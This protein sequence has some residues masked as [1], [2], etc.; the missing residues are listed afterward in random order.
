MKKSTPARKFVR[1]NHI[2][3]RIS[4]M[5]PFALL[6]SLIPFIGHAQLSQGGK[7]LSFDSK[8]EKTYRIE[9]MPDVD[10]QKAIAED[11]L[12]DKASPYRFGINIPVDL[13]VLAMGET[14]I[15]AGGD[16]LVRFGIQSKGALSLNLTF[17]KFKL[18][19]GGKLFIYNADQT[20]VIGAFTDFN[21]Q[22][23]GQFATMLLKG[24]EITLEYFEPAEVNFKTELTVGIVTHGYKDVFG[25]AKAFG[26]SGSCETNVNCPVAADWQCEKRS[27]VM[28]LVNNGSGLCS[29]ALVNNTKQ[30]KA[31]LVLTAN[32]CY[33]P[34]QS[35]STWVFYF[36]WESATCANP[37]S[38]PPKS[39][40]MTGATLKANS[41]GSDFAL[42]QINNPVPDA[43]NASYAGWSRA[44]TTVSSAFAIHH[45]SGD[46]KKFS[47]AAGGTVGSATVNLG[48]GPADCWQTAQWT[49]G[50]TEPGS[51]GSPL[52]DPQHRIVGQLYG[53]PSSCT[54]SAANKFDYYGKFHV[55]WTGG[56]SSATRLQDWLDPNGSNPTT[57]NTLGCAPPPCTLAATAT[58]SAPIACF[59]GTT[60]VVVSATGGAAPVTGTGTF[61]VGTGAY[62]FTVTD[63]NGCKSTA[64]GNISQPTELKATAVAGTILCKGGTTTVV[65]SATGGTAPYTGTGTFTVSAGAYSFTV[66]DKNGCKKTVSGSISEPP[67]LTVEAGNCQFVYYGYGSNCATLT[68]VGAGGV[69][70]Y[71]YSWSSGA[72]TASASVCPIITTTYTVTVKDANGCKATDIVTVEVIDVRCGNNMDKVQICHNGQS[73]CVAANS[74]ANHLSH[75]DKLGVCGAPTP[76]TGVQALI[77]NRNSS[78]SNKP[79]GDKVEMSIFPNPMQTNITVELENITEGVAQLEIL[80]MT[81]RKVYQKTESMSAGFNQ[82]TLDLQ[83]LSKGLYLVRLRDSNNQEAMVK[84]NKM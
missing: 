59:G 43:F 63:A 36:N 29:G 70:G 24:D 18:P 51:S 2:F 52:F 22:K 9:T 81:G 8:M 77:S 40:T 56:G 45:P 46:I 14:Q 83:S 75:G 61:T 53:G 17:S 50:V 54:A 32:H 27:V 49:L 42:V 6:L 12:T 62:S 44:G 65:V 1:L 16:K 23:D 34:A 57:L 38:S 66:T 60:T 37:S 55:S 79:L 47:I 64:S 84:V 20:M 48:H 11:A 67:A 82:V 19:E 72:T 41:G 10:V 71:T 26:S 74:V 21:N 80:D 30:D 35:V 76:C 28:L 69:G 15:L 13:N 68:A 33:D 7:P 58:A 31:P 5:F 39:Q 25:Y 78:A 3:F 73:L 4:L